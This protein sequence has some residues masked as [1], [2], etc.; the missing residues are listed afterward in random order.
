MTRNKTVRKMESSR[1]IETPKSKKTIQ[2]LFESSDV[3]KKSI[4]KSE[5]TEAT[6]H[7]CEEFK[8]RKSF[9]RST[10]LKE[11]FGKQLDKY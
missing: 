2:M 11:L 6:V 9:H 4:P 3:S 5:W 8:I 1:N 10:T 7:E